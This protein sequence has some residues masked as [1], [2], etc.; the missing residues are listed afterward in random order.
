ML[1][2]QLYLDASRPGVTGN[3]GERFAQDGENVAGDIA[4]HERVEGADEPNFRL[5]VKP[6]AGL[7]HEGE[8]PRTKTLTRKAWGLELEDRGAYLADR[9]VDLVERLLDPGPRPLI[10]DETDR[11]L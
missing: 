6:T 4:P 8:H 2:Q 5:E 3:V 11:A 10:L 9:R 7:A 1:E